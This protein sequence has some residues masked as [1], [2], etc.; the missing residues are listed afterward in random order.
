MTVTWAP[1][2]QQ[3]LDLDG[4]NIRADRFGAELLSKDLEVIGDLEWDADR[5]PTITNDATQNVPRSVQSLYL[6][7]G[8]VDDINPVSDRARFYMTLQNGERFDLGVFLWAVDKRPERPWGVE[9]ASSMVDQ[10]HIL[11]QPM[12]TSTGQNKG[13]NII[14]AALGLIF[15]L[16]PPERVTWQPSSAGLSAPVANQPGA[17]RLQV[18][19]DYMAKAGYLP[20]YFDR[21]GQLILRDAPEITSTTQPDHVYELGGRIIADSITGGDDLLDAH[22]RFVA[23]ESSGQGAAVVGRYDIPAIAPHS[24]AN[25]GFPV[26]RVESVQG[27]Q[28]TAQAVRAARCMYLT[29]GKP[30]RT[31]EFS[32]TADPRHD[33]WD[34]VRLLGELYIETRWSMTLRSGEPMAHTVRRLFQ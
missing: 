29:D 5:P 25:R 22:N 20:V 11:D 19:N 34:I 32:S 7:A 27:I 9:A 14:V 23:Y 28:T 26:T 2:T 12:S 3:I 21:H 17:N 8:T 6:P 10:C 30:Y 13:A 15:A 16:I 31:K 18:V 4:V 1:T 33:T 24:I